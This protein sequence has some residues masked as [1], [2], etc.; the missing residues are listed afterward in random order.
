VLEVRPRPRLELGRKWWLRQPP[1]SEPNK[2]LNKRPRKL[3]P[4]LRQL[5]PVEPPQTR[6]G[7]LGSTGLSIGMVSVGA[8][9]GKVGMLL[10]SSACIVGTSSRLTLWQR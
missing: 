1:A 2:R 8:T 3:R 6:L 10:G 5:Q 7:K 4:L 9:R